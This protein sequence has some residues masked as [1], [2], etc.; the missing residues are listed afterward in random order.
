VPQVQALVAKHK[1]RVT[2]VHTHIGSGSDPAVW[3]RTSLMSIN[4]CRAF[5]EVTTLNLGG[6]Y[7]V[8]RMSYEKARAQVPHPLGRPH[9]AAEHR[10][11]GGGAA[12]AG[13]L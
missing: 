10:P 13:R 1:L 7:K 9:A 2:R 5:P 4:L 6:G 12:C 3:Q 11:G 8:G